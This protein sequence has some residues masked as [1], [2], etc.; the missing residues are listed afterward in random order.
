MMHQAVSERG[1][2]K[3]DHLKALAWRKAVDADGVWR[4]GLAAGLSAV[5]PCSW[6]YGTTED[7]I[8]IVI[9]VA[10][11]WVPA[12]KLALNQKMTPAE[13]GLQRV[14]WYEHMMERTRQL[15]IAGRGNGQFLSIID[16]GSLAADLS[17]S[18][19][20]QAWPYLK[21]ANFVISANYGGCGRRVYLARLPK[22][23]VWSW[24]VVSKFL[25]AETREKIAVVSPRSAPAKLEHFQFPQGNYGGVRIAAENLPACLG[26]TAT[27]YEGAPPMHYLPPEEGPG[28][29]RLPTPRG[30]PG[31]GQG[32]WGCY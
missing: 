8:P 5:Q 30:S 14:Y 15:Q 11:N 7:G 16:F 25:P 24:R 23:I 12:I 27:D 21:E 6:G 9:D 17:Y 3:K 4:D 13:F 19:T 18:E 32:G 26:G 20:K 29:P 2:L 10:L 1:R 28:T 22:V 31:K